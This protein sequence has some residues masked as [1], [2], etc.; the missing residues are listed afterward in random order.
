M[1]KFILLLLTLLSLQL[2]GQNLSGANRVVCMDT[3]DFNAL[4][5]L[6]TDL[7]KARIV[8]IGEAGH[9]D[10]KTFEMKEK[11]IKYLVIKH[12]FNTIA[13]EGAG[14]VETPYALTSLKKDSNTYKE[15]EK[16]LDLKWSK[17]QQ[18][19]GL[20]D[21]MALNYKN[22][23]I[24]IYGFDPQPTSTSYT[25][26]LFDFLAD[27]SAR[28]LTHID[29]TV[30]AEY[31]T[32]LRSYYKQSTGQEEFTLSFDEIKTLDSLT[33]IYISQSESNCSLVKQTLLNIQSCVR[34]FI[35]NME[36]MG[37][38]DRSVNSRDS[39]MA[40]NI[41]Y[42][43]DRNPQA[44]MIV[45]GANFHIIKDLS[46]ITHH[47][48]SLKYKRIIPMGYFIAR[49][50]KRSSFTIAFTNGGGQNGYCTDT[51]VYDVIKTANFPINANT[52]EYIF[53]KSKCNIASINCS[54]AT[55]QLK[56]QTRSLIFGGSMHYGYWN[57]AFDCIMYIDKQI[58]ST[59]RLP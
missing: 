32:K 6:D 10:G 57:K 44:K 14:F 31:L 19:K 59:Y 8:L 5:H 48:D 45:S 50:Y 39:V 12:G 9:G 35:Y 17:S 47:Y 49:K 51:T 20:L 40:L 42:Y 15:F 56:Q 30:F 24:D 29:K 7:S 26:K 2:F 4:S 34:L 13:L 33:R 37:Y 16:C 21:F 36:E 43:L 3:S 22:N 46:L 55:A 1:N 25:D 54:K 18:M 11:L 23:Q 58:P 27:S 38:L 53:K 41:F 52:L 28:C